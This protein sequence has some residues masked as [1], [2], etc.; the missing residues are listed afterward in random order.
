VCAVLCMQRAAD[1]SQQHAPSRAPRRRTDI[2][3]LTIVDGPRATRN[4]HRGYSFGNTPFDD[5]IR[6][7]DMVMAEFLLS[8]GSRNMDRTDAQV[9]VQ[10]SALR[11]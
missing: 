9:S 1:P 3:Q 7:G 2:T 10:C 5:A 6:E 11:A 8:K 4:M